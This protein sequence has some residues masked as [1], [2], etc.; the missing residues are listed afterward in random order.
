[1]AEINEERVADHEARLLDEGDKSLSP[2]IDSQ[3]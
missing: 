3:T 2:Q 1:M